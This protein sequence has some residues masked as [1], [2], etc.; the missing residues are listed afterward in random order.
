MAYKLICFDMD[1]VIFKDVN[2]WMALHKKFGTLEEGKIL[3]E[4]YL[5]SDYDKLIEEVVVKLWKGRDMKPYFELVNSIEY[6]DGVKEVF[7]FIKKKKYITA[8]IS[9][10][11]ID[12]AKRAQK[13]L[14]ITYIF[15][16]ELVIKNN[17]ISGEFI[18]PIGKGDHKKAMVLKELCKKLKISTKECI[19]IG[20]GKRDVEIAKE[21]G[22]AIAFNSTSDELKKVSKYVVDSDNLS[23]ILKYLK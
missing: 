10:S 14:D 6:I 9:A 18:W 2:F 22:L 1:G 16:N 8:I 20:D 12:V 3:T 17:K 21:A 4:K 19:F 7:K 23:D 11:S 15:A 5:H 13:E